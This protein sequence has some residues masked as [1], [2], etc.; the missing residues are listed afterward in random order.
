MIRVV[1]LSFIFCCIAATAATATERCNAPYAPQIPDGRTAT[2]E[3]M[4]SARRDANAFIAASDL[5]Q[6]C[7]IRIGR[8][9]RGGDANQR[10]KERIG[11]AFNAAIA[12]FRGAHRGEVELSSR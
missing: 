1:A 12:A 9:E 5:Y 10:E 3:E 7:Q 2:Q 6:L 11:S 4:T 8:G